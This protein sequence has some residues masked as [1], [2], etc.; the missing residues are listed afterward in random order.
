MSVNSFTDIYSIKSRQLKYIVHLINPI[1]LQ[2]AH[3]WTSYDLMKTE[4]QIF[5]EKQLRDFAA[6]KY[7]IVFLNYKALS[8]IKLNRLT[9]IPCGP[10][11]NLRLTLGGNEGI[12]C[13]VIFQ[14][15]VKF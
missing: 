12:A 6:S 4:T 13:D 3:A 8:A 7:L 1:Q 2:K 5:G 11:A 9:Q 15:A 14:S 10:A